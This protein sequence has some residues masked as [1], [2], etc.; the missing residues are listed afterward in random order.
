MSVELVT[1]DLDTVFHLALPYTPWGILVEEY[2]G[3][4]SAVYLSKGNNGKPIMDVKTG[5]VFSF[6]GPISNLYIHNTKSQPGH[7]LRLLYTTEQ[8]LASLVMPERPNPEVMVSGSVTVG[9]T[10]VQLPDHSVPSGLAVALQADRDNTVPIYL[11]DADIAVGGGFELV[12]G[13]TTSI[14]VGNSSGIYAIA[15]AAGQS[16]AF[17]IGPSPSM[18]MVSPNPPNIA[19]GSV[20]LGTIATQFPAQAIPGGIPV[21]IT[22][23]AA[24]TDPIYIGG[25][26]VTIATGTRL[27]PADLIQLTV[28][29]LNAVYGVSAVA[30]QKALYIVEV[31]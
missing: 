12:P 30:S 7:K 19:N 25:S 8:S 17:S 20:T 13:A 2:T 28:D 4:P 6:G 31:Y 14:M 29:N 23:D 18:A 27:G 1:Y 3:A 21:L 16:L 22:A 26:G 10:A 5:R 9:A 11:G 15:A 24:N